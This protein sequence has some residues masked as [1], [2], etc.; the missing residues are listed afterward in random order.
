MKNLQVE[1]IR[2]D[3]SLWLAIVSS[4]LVEENYRKIL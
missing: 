2:D 3:I 4:W 1:E